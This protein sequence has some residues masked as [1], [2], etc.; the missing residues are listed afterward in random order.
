MRLFSEIG[1]CM[2]TF[3]FWN[4]HSIHSSSNQY[5]LGIS[6]GRYPERASLR[7]EPEVPAPLG[8]RDLGSWGER[9]GKFPR[10]RNLILS[11]IHRVCISGAKR[12]F[13]GPRV[14]WDQEAS[15]PPIGGQRSSLCSAPKDQHSRLCPLG[16]PRADREHWGAAEWVLVTFLPLLWD[17]NPLGSRQ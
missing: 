9:G 2:I 4:I 8:T 12:P 13:S 3:P 7:A 1:L 10:G 6:M 14:W 5:L 15:T 17:P 11:K 16:T